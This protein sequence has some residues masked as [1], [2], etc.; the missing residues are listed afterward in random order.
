MLKRAARYFLIMILTFLSVS[1]LVFSFLD[2]AEGD[3]SAYV[4]P[5]D[6]AEE[7]IAAYREA[8]G[9]NRPFLERYSGFMLSFMKGEWGLSAAGHDIKSMIAHSVPVTI[10]IAFSSIFLAL[11]ISVPLSIAAVRSKWIGCGV[12]VLSTVLMIMPSFLLSMVLVLLF[13]VYF[14]AFPV[15]GYVPLSRG[16]ILHVRSIFLPSLT[17]ALLHSSLLMLLF[18]RSLR[19]NL[20]EPYARAAAAAGL[21]R[22]LILFKSATRPALPLL[23]MVTGESAAAFLGGSAAVETVF[24]LPGLGTLMVAAA[25]GRD[26]ALSSVIVMLSALMVSLVSL[27]TETAADLI[28]P[29]RRRKA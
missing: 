6:A 8:Q 14:R 11:L 12:S 26:T 1:F 2:M 9:L 19:E 18:R 29:R 15:A 22:R 24:A 16:F 13:S 28:D 23:V 27:A 25:L 4:L 10:S 21:S 3:S 17:L 5:E 20:S 7:E